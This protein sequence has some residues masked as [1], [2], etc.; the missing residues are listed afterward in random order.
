M[1]RPFDAKVQVIR[2]STYIPP[3]LKQLVILTF[4]LNRSATTFQ[5]YSNRVPNFE[6]KSLLFPSLN[7]GKDWFKAPP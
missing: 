3:V 7:N 6:L 2:V 1:L 4:F 5:I